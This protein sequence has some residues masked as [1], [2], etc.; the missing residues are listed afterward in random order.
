MRIHKTTFLLLMWSFNNH[1]A[2]AIPYPVIPQMLS[3][4]YC[5][6]RRRRG[7]GNGKERLPRDLLRPSLAVSLSGHPIWCLLACGQTVSTPDW[8]PGLT[9]LR[10]AA[11]KPYE[12]AQELK[13][14]C[15]SGL[16]PRFAPRTRLRFARPCTHSPP[17]RGK[18][19]R[20]K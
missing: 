5:T 9:G 4:Q 18:R 13:Q 20:I 17:F 15:G 1:E 3:Q 14:N 11:F 2:A 12:V 16:G 7:G 10:R 6:E 8:T 19:N